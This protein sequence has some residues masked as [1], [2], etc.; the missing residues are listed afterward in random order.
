MCSGVEDLMQFQ[1]VGVVAELEDVALG[2]EHVLLV[3]GQLE[4]LD[5]LDG[6]LL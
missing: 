4:F 5:D 2:F 1:N 6:H 3:E